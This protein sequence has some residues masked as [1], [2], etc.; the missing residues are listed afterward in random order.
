MASVRWVTRDSG[1]YQLGGLPGI[2]D[3]ISKV[4]YQG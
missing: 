4:G 1:W 3:G 2:V